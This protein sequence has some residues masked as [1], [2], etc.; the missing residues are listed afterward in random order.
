MIRLPSENNHLG[1]LDGGPFD[2][3]FFCLDFFQIGS[4]EVVVFY[5]GVGFYFVD[6]QD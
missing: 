4:G 2:E 3:D 5:V 1:P 6:H